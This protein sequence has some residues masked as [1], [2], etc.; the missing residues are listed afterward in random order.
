MEAATTRQQN[1]TSSTHNKIGTQRLLFNVW[2]RGIVLWG[3]LVVVLFLGAFKGKTIGNAVASDL[4]KM[5]LKGAIKSI[6]QRVYDAGKKNGIIKKR[7]LMLDPLENW[8]IEFNKKGYIQEKKCYDAANELIFYYEYKYKKKRLLVKKNMYDHR[9]YRIEQVAYVYN[10]FGELA[11]ESIYGADNTLLVRYIHTYSPKGLL[12][13][14]DV[15]APSSRY[16]A[17]KYEFVYNKKGLVVEEYTYNNKDQL[18]Q[19]NYYSYDKNDY[20]KEHTIKNHLDNFTFTSYSRYDERGNLITYQA[21]AEK[22]PLTSYTYTFDEHGNW[23][24]QTHY[25][26]GSVQQIIERSIVYD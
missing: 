9:N 19:T 21:P 24:C 18:H 15:H 16:T 22:E 7:H 4:E 5:R 2:K 13:E 12:K 1:V 23:T 20:V 25:K 14:T 17:S 8:D 26:K 11:A 10:G 3:S 6:S